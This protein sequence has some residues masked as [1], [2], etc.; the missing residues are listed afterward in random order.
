MVLNKH[1]LKLEEGGQAEYTGPEGGYGSLKS[2]SEILLRERVPIKAGRAL[3]MQNKPK[4]F[5][6]VS[7]AWAK[8]ARPHPAE[9][10]EN[11]AKATAWEITSKRTDQAFFTDHTLTELETWRDHDLEAAGRLTHPM[12]LDP[13]S[14][15]Y[16]PVSWSTAFQ[17][18]GRELKA[19]APQEAVFYTSGRASLE[20]SYM[21]QLFARIYGSNHLPDSSNMCHERSSV[22]LPQSIGS[23]VG[24]ATLQDFD[25]CD[26]IFFIAQNVGTSLPRM[27][28]QLQEA[29]QRGV[30]TITINP[31]RERGLERFTNPQSPSEMLTGAETPI[32]SQYLQVKNGGDIGAL[33]GICKAVIEMG[34]ATALDKKVVGDDATPG[35]PDNA[36]S[37]AF[38]AS[39]AAADMK[40]V[41]D[42]G[43]IAEHTYGFEEF[44]A[45]A[46]AHDW[47]ELEADQREQG[48]RQQIAHHEVDALRYGLLRSEQPAR[49]CPR[50]VEHGARGER[51]EH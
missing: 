39:I 26:C 45:A 49:P 15:C 23:S 12:R 31:L 36:A 21:Y 43:F 22:A 42:H 50:R 41:L 3:S 9:F 29:V 14:D 2:V 1:T 44:A 46:R 4:G 18:I 28:H 19:I 17:E 5:M 33:F 30:K 10:C 16:M 7:C 11:G 32:S 40:R 8:P 38:A 37:V 48:R 27:M 20:T 34:D 13:D 47:A 25:S 24:T 51:N 35:E 6:C